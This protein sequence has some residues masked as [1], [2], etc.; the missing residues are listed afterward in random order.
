M[1]ESDDRRRLT[2]LPSTPDYEARETDS[3][4]PH[5]DDV[6]VVVEE[7]SPHD[8]ETRPDAYS[9]LLSNQEKSTQRCRC[10]TRE[11]KAITV[12]FSLSGICWLMLL[13]LYATSSTFLPLFWRESISG[14][15]S[16]S[17]TSSSTNLSYT[18]PSQT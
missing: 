18:A 4:L 17:E 3:F 12:V 8:A 5:D 9:P 2:R 13:A 11:R 10:W 16:T 15:G 6:E 1:M 14:C 7:Q